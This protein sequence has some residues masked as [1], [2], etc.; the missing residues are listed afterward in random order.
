MLA[1]TPRKIR[2]YL[3]LEVIVVGTWLLRPRMHLLIVLLEC[4]RIIE[5]KRA[6]S[7]LGQG[8]D[9]VQRIRIRIFLKFLPRLSVWG[10]C[11]QMLKTQRT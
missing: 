7:P 1:L 2:V 3:L 4:M 11:R 9:T 8:C 6:F 10:V 5:D